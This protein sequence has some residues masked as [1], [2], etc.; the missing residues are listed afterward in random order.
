MRMMKAV[1]KSKP[2][3]GCDVT[4]I[5]Y[6][7]L[8]PGWIIIKVKECGICGSDIATAYLRPWD[9]LKRAF[10]PNQP[11][12]VLG[13]EYVGEVVEIGEGVSDIGI[14]DH[15]T[16]NPWYW[17]ACGK[18]E[19]CRSYRPYDCRS[20][21]PVQRIGAMA[22]YTSAPATFVHKLP[23]DLSWDDGVLIEPFTITFAAVYDF[24]SFR[25]GK[26]AAVLGPGPIGLLTLA[27]L[28][29]STPAL[30]VITGTSSDVSPRLEIAKKLGADIT[31][32]VNEEDP[33]KRVMEL[34][35][36]HGVEYVYET[37][38]VP[39]L[40]QGI[41]ML[42]KEGEY[43]AI[44]HAHGETH[45]IKLDSGDYM[46]LQSKWAKINAIVLEKSSVWFTVIEL[47]KKRKIDLKQVITH[48]VRIEDATEGCELMRKQQ[49]GKII[50][51]P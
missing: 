47:M 15:V 1:V 3:A 16:V 11:Y 48:H 8:K 14:G 39:L 41:K 25:V 32:N 5:P 29:L 37:A 42:A 24:S 7:D 31:I 49:G 51:T 27:A 19:S 4:E 17:N 34:T 30:T 38:G 21:I 44:G 33:V 9:E 2:E 12:T 40:S 28:E 10:R 18:C 36:G 6:P 46:M 20:P 22:E 35:G 50:V 43:T 45:P 13:H 23:N 26:T